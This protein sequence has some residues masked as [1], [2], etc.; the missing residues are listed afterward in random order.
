MHKKTWI[1]FFIILSSLVF[2]IIFIINFLVDPHGS[3]ELVVE[4]Y[5]KPVL[6]ER[7]KKYDYIFYQKNFNKYDCLILGSSR[8]MKIVPQNNE[9]T[10]HCYN[11]GVHAAN[12]AEKLFILKEWVKRKTLKKVLL[13]IEFYSFHASKN[14]LHVNEKKFKDGSSGNYL[15]ISTLNLSYKSLIY[16]LQNKPQTYFEDDGSINYHT[17]DQLIQKNL[18]NFSDQTFQMQSYGQ[19]QK[20][21]I[22]DPFVIEEKVFTILQE[23]RDMSLKHSFEL[24]VF[25]TPQH[26]EM[27]KLFHSNKKLL[28]QFNKIRVQTSSIFKNFSDFSIKND[29]NQ[30]NEYFYDP[31]HY[32]EIYAN[33]IVKVITN[34]N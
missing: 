30:K 22:E 21:F 1:Q 32:R 28:S 17:K 3:R 27:I 13:G 6:N 2:F 15:A 12:N 26:K 10:K 33:E 19:F 5:F 16:K 9:T 34:P 20:N 29:Y 7:N 25:L 4:K 8:V 11:F 23:I 14:P 31:W 24:D 18:Y